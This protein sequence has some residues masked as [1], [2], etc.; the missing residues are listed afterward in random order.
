LKR[1]PPDIDEAVS[2]GQRTAQLMQDVAQVRVRLA[3]GRVGPQQKRQ[4]LTR[5]RRVAM[6]QQVGQ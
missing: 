2:L 5:L 4:A 1:P 6:Q 3:L